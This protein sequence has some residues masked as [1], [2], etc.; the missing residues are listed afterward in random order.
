MFIT[1]CIHNFLYFFIQLLFATPILNFLFLVNIYLF[2]WLFL[3]PPLFFCWLFF[4]ILRI[5]FRFFL[6]FFLW[7]P[8]RL[9]FWFSF[10]T[11]RY[12]VIF[13]NTFSEWFFVFFFCYSLEELVYRILFISSFFFFCF[14]FIVRFLLFL[15]VWAAATRWESLCWRCWGRISIYI[16]VW[17]I[18]SRCGLVFIFFS[19]LHII[20]FAHI[21]YVYTICPFHN[22]IIRF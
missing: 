17:I 10:R 15:L 9:F 18:I 5:F 3:W 11:P 2:Y 20:Q 16:Y 21:F 6:W 7:F 22:P 12:F 14:F 8:V 19:A 13:K 4:P 1:D